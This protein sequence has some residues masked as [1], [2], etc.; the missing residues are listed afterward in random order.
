MSTRARV[1]IAGAAGRDFH[2]FNTVYRDDPTCEV[3]AFT[4][5]QI[6]GIDHRVYPA[7]LAGSLYPRGIPIRPE[8]ELETLCSG[9]GVDR[10][11]FAYSDVAHEA[12]MHLGSRALAAGADFLLLG[13]KQTM[14]A[15]RVPV[16]AVSAVRTGCG[17]SQT[18]RW[19]TRHLT[20][21]GIR[22]VALRHPMPYGDLAASRVQRFATR[23]DLSAEHCTAEERE[24]FEPYIEHGAVVYAGVDYPAI[25]AE[26]EKEAEMLVWDGGN[27]DF[28]FLRPDLHIALIDALRP[29]DVDTYHPGETVARMADVLI[30]N[31]VSASLP[32]A[33]ERA[34]ETA[35]RLNPVAPLLH[36]DSPVHLDDP[37]AVRGKRVLVVEDGPT[38][39]HG[40]M[41][42]GAGYVASLAA[43]AK[44]IVDPRVSAAP[45]IAA[46]YAQYPHL[47][48][49]LPAMGYDE[50]QLE[51]LRRTIAESDAEVVVS[52]SPIDLSQLLRVQRP[53]VRARYE[54]QD[55]DEPG[56]LGV[57]EAF[58]ADPP[59]R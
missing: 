17:K 54:Y 51:A 53:I 44:E 26:A 1:L 47:T 23:K 55:L 45:E 59:R 57:L 8:T 2:C 4:A 49:V 58:L 12:V 42:F 24:E 3:V 19:I 30:L 46:V 35:R 10:V 6:P 29:D 40:G 56:L 25:L 32:D 21:R 11:V 39:T 16:I 13:P 34:T 50:H 31:K 43:G 38:V 41:R 7:E 18:A 5:T 14:L 36:A 28:P 15:A 27:N 48:K 9:E 33:L 22:T 37:A 20:E 52:G